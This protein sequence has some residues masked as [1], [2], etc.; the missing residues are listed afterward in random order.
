MTNPERDM[1]DRKVYWHSRR[2]MAELDVLLMPYSSEVYPTLTDLERGEFKRLL[3][4]EDADLFAWFMGHATPDDAG[5]QAV[6]DQVLA[7]ARTRHETA[8]ST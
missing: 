3:A 1:D 2:G 5:F 6:I 8:H 4:A 7:Y